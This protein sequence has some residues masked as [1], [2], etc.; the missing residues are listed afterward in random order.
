M[1]APAPGGIELQAFGEP[2]ASFRSRYRFILKLPLLV[3][4]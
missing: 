1:V 2:K 3:S 4:V